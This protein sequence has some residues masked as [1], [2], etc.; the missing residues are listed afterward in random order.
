DGS[1]PEV[2]A[3]AAAGLQAAVANQDRPLEY[4]FADVGRTATD[5]PGEA[6]PPSTVQL[7]EGVDAILFG[8]VG[9]PKWESLPPAEQ[10][11][12][13]ALLPL[14]K[15]FDLYCN[16][17]PGKVYKALVPSCPLRPDIVGDGFDILV[18]REL[19]GG[20]YFAQQPTDKGREGSGSGERAWDTKQYTRAQVERIAHKAF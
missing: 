14:R 11:E 18:V 17:R 3:G 4:E 12:R 1:G 19:T 10:P 9:G 2:S 6:L 7:C 20:A 5:N 8:S 16:L 15:R 13:A